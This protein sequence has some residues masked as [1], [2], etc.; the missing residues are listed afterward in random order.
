M[1]SERYGYRFDSEDQVWYKKINPAKARQ[2]RNEA[3][4]LGFTVANMIRH[5]KGLEQKTAFNLGM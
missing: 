5:E 2:A 3:D 1:K 4:Q